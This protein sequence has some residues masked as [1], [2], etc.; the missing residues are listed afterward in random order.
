MYSMEEMDLSSGEVICEIFVINGDEYSGDEI[1][2][3]EQVK[4]WIEE[5]GCLKKIIGHVQNPV[6]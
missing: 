3:L 1:S 5:K 2:N 4:T 6:T